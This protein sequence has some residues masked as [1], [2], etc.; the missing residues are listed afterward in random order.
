MTNSLC[1]QPATLLVAFPFVLFTV[2]S[3]KKNTRTHDPFLRGRNVFFLSPGGKYLFFRVSIPTT[4]G[5]GAQ[6]EPTSHQKTAQVHTDDSISAGD[7]GN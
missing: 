7:P 4:T 1:P 3:H 5:P 6:E 2:P